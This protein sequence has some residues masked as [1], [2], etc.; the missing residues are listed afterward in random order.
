MSS[1]ALSLLSPERVMWGQIQDIPKLILTKQISES[2]LWALIWS[3][4][5]GGHNLSRGS[6]FSA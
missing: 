3:L 5:P 1:L 4:S 6:R 2:V